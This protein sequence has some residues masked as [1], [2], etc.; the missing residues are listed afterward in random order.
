VSELFL[1]RRP[2]SS[3]QISQA[4]TRAHLM[5]LFIE[6]WRS[7]ITT[8]TETLS[9]SEAKG[10]VER[11]HGY[12]ETSFLP[13]RSFRDPGDFNTQ[14]AAWLPRANNRVHRR[15][16]CRPTEGIEAD[17]AAMLSLPPVAPATG[18][19]YRIRLPRDHYAHLAG[20]RS[21]E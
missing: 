16:D 20:S 7:K 17:R 14:L 12:L 13:G 5:I 11:A 3:L 9:P 1:L 21:S 15:I 4:A 2:G 19:S 18:L 6:R 8:R 10:L